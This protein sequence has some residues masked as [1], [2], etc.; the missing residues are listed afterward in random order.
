MRDA[1]MMQLLD[2][3]FRSLPE[4]NPKPS[5]NETQKVSTERSP[6]LLAGTADF[7]IKPI[8]VA[9]ARATT[10][11]VV[12]ARGPPKIRRPAAVADGPGNTGLGR[13]QRK[14]LGN[15]G[16]SQAAPSRACERPVISRERLPR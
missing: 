3:G 15:S 16:G 8:P 1:Q 5:E 11:A 2:Q 14:E 9:A 12:A 7:D 10:V 4:R 13:D 6:L